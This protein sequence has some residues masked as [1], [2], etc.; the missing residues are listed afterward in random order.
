M[1]GKA[2][3]ERGVPDYWRKGL[4]VEVLEFVPEGISGVT[5][6]NKKKM[7]EPIM[8][9]LDVE[10]V[11]NG[12]FTVAHAKSLLSFLPV[13]L[14]VTLD[15]Q[16]K[17]DLDKSLTYYIKKVT[18]D[19]IEL[20]HDIKLSKPVVPPD[21]SVP[22]AIL[23]EHFID[24]V[25]I[26][27]TGNA[28]DVSIFTTSNEFAHSQTGL[29]SGSVI[30]F[31]ED[32]QASMPPHIAALKNT[33]YIVGILSDK[34]FT[35][36]SVLPADESKPHD[37]LIAGQ[38]VCGVSHN[39]PKLPRMLVRKAITPK[40]H[41]AKIASYTKGNE[42]CSVTYADGTSED[43]VNMSRLRLSGL[44][45][46]PGGVLFLDEAYDLNPSTNESGRA[47]FN[48]IMQAAEE[49]RDR[50]TII[51]AGYKKDIESKLYAY[52]PGMASRIRSVEFPDFSVEELGEIW[53]GLCEKELFL[54]SP[55]VTNIATR[56]VA[57]GIGKHGF[58]N[59]RTVRNVF[60][61]ALSA[62]KMRIKHTKSSE[63]SSVN[64]ILVEDVIGKDP[65]RNPEVEALFKE[66][67]LLVGQAAVKERFQQFLQVAKSNYAKE[68]RAAEGVEAVGVDDMQLNR[69]FLGSPG[70]GKTT[71]AGLY[72]R[73]L[74]CLGFLSNGEYLK[75]DATDFVADAVGGTQNKA[76]AL[77]ES[78]KGKVL[79]IDE[80]YTLNDNE[81]G[82]EAINTL[83]GRVQGVPGEDIA[84]VL[85]GYTD[86][87]LKMLQEANPGLSSRFDV[88]S[89]FEFSDF[90]DKEMLQIFSTLCSKKRPPVYAPIEVKIAAVK[91]LAMKRCLPNFGNARSVDVV[92][93]NAIGQMTARERKSGASERHLALSDIET[94]TVDNVQK[95]LAELSEYG[96]EFQ[97]LINQLGS[98]I[99]LHRQEGRQTTVDHYVFTG[100]P[101]TGK[102]WAART[103][104]NLLHEF[105][106]V[107]S[108]T[109]IETSASD[110]L[111]QYVG[112]TKDNVD[113]AVQSAQGGV[114]FIDEAYEL[115]KSRFG[116]EGLTQLVGMLT[117]PEFMHGKTVVILA[118]YQRAMEEMFARNVG[119][120]SRFKKYLN[121]SDWPTER[122]I[123]LISKQLMAI[124]P[125]PFL[126][127][128]TAKTHLEHMLDEL[129]NLP[130][131]GN[132]R[133]ADTLCKMLV[134]HR[135]NRRCA[136]NEAGVAVRRDVEF[137]IL[138]QDVES[139]KNEF[140][141]SRKQVPAVAPVQS[142]A[143]SSGSI[144]A[145]QLP[146]DF[147]ISVFAS[148]HPQSNRLIVRD[149]LFDEKAAPPPPSPDSAGNAP[150]A[151]ATATKT[152]SIEIMRHRGG[153]GEAVVSSGNF[154]AAADRELD[155]YKLKQ[156]SDR[157]A[158]IGAIRSSE[159]GAEQQKHKEIH[160]IQQLIKSLEAMDVEEAEDILDQELER[161]KVM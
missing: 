131:W 2:K 48:S 90:S 145:V 55:Q 130:F 86:R 12:T 35:I 50:V 104:A 144:S 107:A 156:L 51:L 26:L 69:M 95:L 6:T 114:L 59:A 148:L 158:Q 45:G 9:A 85:C 152:K 159:R 112:H 56:R 94:S 5:A 22:F 37:G 31:V 58:A 150:D 7:W 23:Y 10:R 54:T 155:P 79:L 29:V 105:G 17:I 70:T 71:F 132:G 92:L 61:L 137:L 49:Y 3:D 128:D 113:K 110:L 100:N 36:A 73:L 28:S 33:P 142:K 129:R 75:K 53:K 103:I 151:A 72:A 149:V 87:M 98:R 127:E 32:V 111:G 89:A 4:Q 153:G 74:K 78:A 60:E 122:C 83:V 68:L 30:E 13:G 25:S 41:A 138:P 14:P 80:A 47:I 18:A 154:D 117:R 119:L 161:Q 63:R 66:V 27:K 139:A 64:E 116:E 24:K 65:S 120:K 15:P 84:V 82:R 96:G 99:I 43:A 1:C 42:T 101:G 118:G 97:Q 44:F 67:N 160:R 76:A 146:N 125:R 11:V 52:N 77:L 21:S 143:S 62:A 140:F 136:E 93:T 81:Y 124:R 106:V 126:L 20:A 108:S 8:L 121:F 40:W 109:F 38:R 135:D 147:C 39:L 91:S 88:G 16:A 123:G 141:A 57:R 34:Q 46:K 19:Q 133:D 134:E 102:T 157:I 115:G